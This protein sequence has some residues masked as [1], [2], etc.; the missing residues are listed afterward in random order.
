[1]TENFT[2][3]KYVAENEGEVLLTIEKV[4]KNT[5]HAR[6]NFTDMTVEIIPL[7]EYRTQTRC[8][9]QK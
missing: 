8:I 7:D 6:N 3:N 9:E 2:G 1:M 4:S 5:Y